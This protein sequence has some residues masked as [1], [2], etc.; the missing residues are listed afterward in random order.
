MDPVSK[1]RGIQKQATLELSF[2]LEVLLKERKFEKGARDV[3]CNPC[4]CKDP[5]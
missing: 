5:F 3:P 4:P 2:I 1:I